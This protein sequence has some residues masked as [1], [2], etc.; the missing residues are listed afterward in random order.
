[1]TKNTQE[2]NLDVQ[3]MLR[4]CVKRPI[5]GATVLLLTGCAISA[6]PV[7]N[8]TKATSPEI[9]RSLK[10]RERYNART[11][12]GS[13]VIFIDSVA[14]HH[15]YAEASTVMWKDELGKWQWSQVSEIGPGGM[16]RIERKLESKTER[17]L[18]ASQSAE[19]E[20]LIKKRS[21]YW[22]AISQSGSRGIGAPEQTMEIITPYGRRTYS[23]AGR[24]EGAA[25]QIADLAL[26]KK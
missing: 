3:L 2:T 16:L 19:L 25:G 14:V 1:M 17:A 20:E 24:L 4:L 5:L 10:L 6:K 18:T 13:T 11:N 26:G 23:W 7:I 12:F 22:G 9:T 8:T 15:I 21:L